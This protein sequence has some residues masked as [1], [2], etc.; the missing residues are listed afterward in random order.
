MS[1]AQGIAYVMEL[2]D[3]IEV[4][5]VPQGEGIRQLFFEM[6]TN[7][8]AEAIADFWQAHTLFRILLDCPR[9]MFDENRL[10]D[11]RLDQEQFGNDEPWSEDL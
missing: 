6:H 2:L 11:L 4:A 3:G 1:N 5:P 10:E 8:A 9:E 7:A